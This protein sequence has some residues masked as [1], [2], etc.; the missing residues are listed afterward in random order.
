M[1]LFLCLAKA[2]FLYTQDPLGYLGLVDGEVA[3]VPLNLAIDFRPI[4]NSS[5]SPEISLVDPTSRQALHLA[6]DDGELILADKNGEDAQSF[7]LIFNAVNDF[8]LGSGDQ[9]I[10]YNSLLRLFDKRDCEDG[11]KFSL[12]FEISNQGQQAV[13][14]LKSNAILPV[15]PDESNDSDISENKLQAVD[16]SD[17]NSSAM[18]MNIKDPMTDPN[19][20][21]NPNNI[22]SHKNPQNVNHPLSFYNSRNRF[23]P[24]YRRGKNKLNGESDTM[25]VVKN[26]ENHSI[27]HDEKRRPMRIRKSKKYE[28][29][30]P[31]EHSENK[32]LVSKR[33]CGNKRKKFINLLSRHPRTN[34][35]MGRIRH[36]F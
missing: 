21:D 2:L 30:V 25:P 22:Y 27:S 31:E 36:K 34:A 7:R 9:C 35:L 19:N 14:P 17:K 26:T 16:I 6:S 3:S 4:P 33:S 18:Q 11:T 5:A 12:Y 23:S 32:C 29:S 28:E 8:F 10:G 13:L 15:R 20:R 1:L 24:L